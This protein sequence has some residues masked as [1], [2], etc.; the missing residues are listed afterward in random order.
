MD[1]KLTGRNALVC[2]STDGLGLASARAVSSLGARVALSGRR[3]ERLAELA[4]ELGDAA[5]LA[6]D[7]TVPGSAAEL[8]PRAVAALGGPL[9]ILV[10]NGPG[11]APATAASLTA[12]AVAAAVALLVQNQVEL[13]NQVLPGMR[14]RGWGRI[15]A[16]GSSGVA[17]PLANLATSNLGRSALWA[18]LKTLSA[19][20]AAEGVTVNMVLPGRIATDR[21]A[22]LDEAAAE[23]TGRSVADVRAAAEAAIPARRYGR[24]EEFG[25][26]VGFLSSNAASYVTGSAIRCDGGLV[27]S[28]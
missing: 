14:E 9:D 5:G 13:V 11:P 7:L 19:E 6:V 23:R 10:L 2:A 24:P 25:A 15:V 16:I 18:Y 1:L 22:S 20:V 4:A 28:I 12:E 8:A 21:V 17:S 26:V 3:A 27:G